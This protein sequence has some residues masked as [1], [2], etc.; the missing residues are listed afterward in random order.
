MNVYF[1]SLEYKYQYR[2]KNKFRQL[3]DTMIT[4]HKKVGGDFSFIYTSDQYLLD[5][6]RKYL[7]HNYF[8]DVIT[9]S[10]NENDIVSGDIFISIQ[11]VKFN[12]KKRGISIGDELNRVMIHGILH[13]LGYNDS[14]QGE[15]KEMR[16]KEDHYLNELKNLS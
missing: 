2:G 6:N 16:E 1:N 3:I 12:A 5:M 14:T 8:T 7:E 9:F 11:T 13:L 10:Y 4:K 15:K